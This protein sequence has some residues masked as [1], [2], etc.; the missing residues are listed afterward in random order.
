MRS[1]RSVAYCKCF[2][3][4]LLWGKRLALGKGGCIGLLAELSAGLLDGGGIVYQILGRFV[5]EQQC[6][7]TSY[8]KG[9]LL[10]RRRPFLILLRLYYLTALLCRVDGLVS[11]LDYY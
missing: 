6:S 7:I 8:G 10:H 5:W 1:P 9:R 2:G 4:R 11:L 3:E